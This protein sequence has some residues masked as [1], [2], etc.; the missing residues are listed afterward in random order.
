MKKWGLA[1]GGGGILGLA[2][3]GVLQLIEARGLRPSI[4]TGTSV[5]AIVAGL[6]ASGVDLS[7]VEDVA[8][9]VLVQEDEPLDI[10]GED[11]PHAAGAWSPI[12]PLALSG[13]IGGDMIEAA[14]DRVVR[15]AR[16]TDARM[17][18]AITS[19][20]IITGSIVIFTNVA[21]R[22]RSSMRALE[23]AGRLYVTDAKVA[24]AIRASVSIPG[25][26]KPKRLRSWSL[27]D[28]GIRDMVPAY[29]ARRMGAEEVVAVDLS[30]H[31]EK[32]QNVGNLVAILSRSFQLASRETTE[33]SLTDHASIILQPDVCECGLLTPTRC[34]ELVQAGR[35]CAESHLP[36]LVA[37]LS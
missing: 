18:L 4:V 12:A 34:R 21:P 3:I 32:P 7:G 9:K 22:T 15:G 26:F 17:G 5:G 33:R 25:V 24:E 19:V 2:H 36:R 31:V 20:D 28:G 1:L 29:E 13:L 14:I 16:L 35:T 30:L 6:Y 37:M 27:V 11:A 23:L 10:R 8:A